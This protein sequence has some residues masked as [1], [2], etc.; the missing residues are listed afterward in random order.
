M[1]R[2]GR[3][4]GAA[5]ID[6]DS[7]RLLA[8]SRSPDLPARTCRMSIRLAIDSTSDRLSIA[9]DRD[10]GPPESASLQGARRHAGALLPM[11]DEVLG[12][13]HATSRDLSLVAVADGPGSFTGIRVS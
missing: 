8:R 7:S 4:L 6:P 2:A 13:L 12:R 5:S 11:I 10:G 1:A 9:A 3:S